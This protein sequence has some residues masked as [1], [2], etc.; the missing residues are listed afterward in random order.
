MIHRKSS[1]SGE[2]CKTKKKMAA[3]HDSIFYQINFGV[4]SSWKPYELKGPRH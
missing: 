1:I 2:N 4:F 3:N